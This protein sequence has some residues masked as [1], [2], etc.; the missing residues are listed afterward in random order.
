MS[1]VHKIVLIGLLIWSFIHISLLVMFNGE[2]FKFCER[3]YFIP[4]SN[5]D[6]LLNSGIN[7]TGEVFYI[8]LYDYSEFLVYCCGAWLI[9]LIFRVINS[10]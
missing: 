10:K 6:D 1:R 4:F 2:T 8:D 7:W 9:Y 5:A 3:D